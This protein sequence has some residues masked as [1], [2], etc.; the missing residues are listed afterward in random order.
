MG[1]TGKVVLTSAAQKAMRDAFL[2]WQCRLRQLAVRQ[3]GGR[4]TSGMR[5][6]LSLPGR[7]KPLGYITVLVVKAEPAS[8]TAQF[9]HI[10]KKTHDPTE[11]LEAGLRLLQATYYQQAREF[12]DI[13]T[14][15]FGAQ[16]EAAARLTAEGR[17]ILEF[18]QYSQSFRLPCRVEALR[19]DHPFFAATYWHNSLFNPYL[20]G[21]PRV[22]AFTPDWAHSEAKPPVGPA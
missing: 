21:R 7:E 5:P 13:L 12:S 2:G 6:L 9:R 14:A 20:P 18:E 4:P 1:E 8:H 10:V 19:E 3:A 15:L 16:S 11:R 17:A 22:L